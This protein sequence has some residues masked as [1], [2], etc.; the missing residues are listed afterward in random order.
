MRELLRKP[1]VYVA[2]K[3]LVTSGCFANQV[4]ALAHA[5]WPFEF[6]LVEKAEGVAKEQSVD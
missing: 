3:L 5:V 2:L 4:E 6:T 1:D